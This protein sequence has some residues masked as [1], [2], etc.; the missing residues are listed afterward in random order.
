MTPEMPEEVQKKKVYVGDI[1][2]LI[3]GPVDKL[4]LP[5]T[6]DGQPGALRNDSRDGAGELADY[7]MGSTT[8]FDVMGGCAAYA[9]KNFKNKPGL[10]FLKDMPPL[11]SAEDR[12]KYVEKIEQTQP[13]V[14]M[15]PFSTQEVIS[16]LQ[17]TEHQRQKGAAKEFEQQDVKSKK[18]KA[19]DVSDAFGAAKN[20]MGF[21]SYIPT[22]FKKLF[23][24]RQL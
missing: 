14:E 16:V 2:S 20:E 10:E 4:Q 19:I 1:I 3:A 12:L 21:N 5:P 15:E 8:G 17:I 11:Q 9:A 13:Y 7:L 18:E 23:S 6:D 22:F 24:R